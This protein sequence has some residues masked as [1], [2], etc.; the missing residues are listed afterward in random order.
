MRLICTT[1]QNRFIIN[2]FIIY[3][4]IWLIVLLTYSLNWSH[5]CPSNLTFYCP[6]IIITCIISG[7]IGIRFYKKRIFSYS[8]DKSINLKKITKYNK[9]LYFLFVLEII[10]SK[11]I[12][13]L[14][15]LTGNTNIEYT[16]FG[17]PLI[18]VIV[19]NGFVVICLC[20]FYSYFC[21]SIKQEKK[22]YLK[23]LVFSIIPYF[24]MFNRGGL[25][26]CILGCFI[27]YLMQCKNLKK[28]ILGV[29]S[30]SLLVL[31]GFGVLGNLRTDVKGVNNI[32]L[33][34]GEAS[35]DF[36]SSWIP[37]E[38]FWPYIYISTPIANAQ[39]MMDKSDNDLNLA[40]LT[41]FV[42]FEMTPELLSKR[43]QT[44]GIQE[45]EMDK[46]LYAFNVASVYGMSAKYVSWLG[47]MILYMYW[48]LFVI[49]TIGL[50]PKNSPFYPIGIV[51][52][53]IITIM[54]TFDN[55]FVFMGLI[56]LP[57]IIIIACYNIRFRLYERKNINLC[58]DLQS[59]NH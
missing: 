55:M 26:F 21:T 24:L 19:A 45:K 46:I 11:G 52:V 10:S 20:S 25:M 59:N 1:R 58:G 48:I 14:G 22:I 54:N 27:I 8:L 18:H 42:I 40:D 30:V 56:P 23:N 41:S 43:I 36:T 2:P 34:F 35:D 6:F 31:F 32:I 37:K 33:Q 4:L 47:P 15:Y 50:I 38:F 53:S 28:S 9:I 7:V 29:I 13:I 49:I 5:L 57:L 44:D 17:L 51:S 12:P 16:D 3:S 39:L